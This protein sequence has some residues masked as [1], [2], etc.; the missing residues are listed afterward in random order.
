MRIIW[1]VPRR[2]WT[3]ARAR[4]PWSP[5]PK[6]PGFSMVAGRRHRRPGYWP[7][8]RPRDHGE[9]MESLIHHFKLCHGGSS[10]ASPAR[11]TRT[12]EHTKASWAFTSCPTVA[13]ARS[14]LPRPLVRQPASAG[15][16]DRR[17]PAGPTWLSHWPPSTPFSEAL[18]DG[19][20]HPDTLG[21]PAGGRRDHRPLPG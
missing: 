18:T 7:K 19:A 9:S 4:P 21:T 12:V 14:A 1:Q 11:S 8:A 10:R 13:R 3:S 16:D 6:S 2:S 5:T 20:T 17:R 15:H